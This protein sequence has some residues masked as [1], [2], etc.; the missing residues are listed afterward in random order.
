MLNF[1]SFAKTIPYVKN[2]ITKK[3]YVEN[4]TI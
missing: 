3:W 1:R 2:F 4:F